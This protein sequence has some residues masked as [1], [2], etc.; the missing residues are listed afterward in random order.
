MKEY[1]IY[2]KCNM[3]G[4]ETEFREKRD[5]FCF[6]E[7]NNCSNNIIGQEPHDFWRSDTCYICSEINCK[8]VTRVLLIKN[9]DQLESDIIKREQSKKTPN[10]LYKL[11]WE[12]GFRK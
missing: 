10:L 7:N 4:H 11:L 12:I 1:D 9:T 8:I 5:E 3:C 2:V 6:R